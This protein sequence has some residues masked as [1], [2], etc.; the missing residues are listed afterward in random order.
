MHI[1]AVLAAPCSIMS[2]G[3]CL[4]VQEL[5]VSR[6]RTAELD[7]ALSNHHTTNEQLQ[8]LKVCNMVLVAVAAAVDKVLC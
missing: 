1:V 8:K 3:C 7:S 2:H 6:Q 5:T 4:Q